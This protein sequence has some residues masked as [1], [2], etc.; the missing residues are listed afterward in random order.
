ML[1]TKMVDNFFTYFEMLDIN[2]QFLKVSGSPELS[3]RE[4]LVLRKARMV[5]LSGFTKIPLKIFRS[6]Q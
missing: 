4:L 2:L 1:Y 5:V 3:R 6:Y